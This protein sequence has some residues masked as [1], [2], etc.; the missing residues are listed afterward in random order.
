MTPRP[1][2]FDASVAV[3]WV[4]LEEHTDE[5][6]ALLA[7]S[8]DEGRWLIGPPHLPGE[9][10]NAIYQ[11][12]RS[13]DPAKH[14]DSTQADE[15]L[16]RFLAITIDLLNPPNLYIS[17]LAFARTHRLPSMYDSVYVTLAQL[18]GAELWTAD[19]RLLEALGSRAPWV[20]FIGDY[21]LAP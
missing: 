7:T 5:A 14:L 6:L 21:P 13:T 19:R 8:A 4:V 10:A 17:A 2:A 16:A 20:R 9:V 18:A 3:K 11:R 1:L 15:A 12:W